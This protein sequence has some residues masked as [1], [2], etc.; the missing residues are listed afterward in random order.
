M[1]E[2][3][4][5]DYLQAMGITH[6]VPRMALPNAPQ[7]RWIA[8][9]SAHAPQPHQV[10][11]GEGHIVHPMA[12]ELLHDAAKPAVAKVPESR[13]E[14]LRE[15]AD[16]QQAADRGREPAPAVQPAP[17]P[18]AGTD[19]TPPRFELQFLRVSHY[20]VWVSDQPHEMER[21]QGFA[22]R[23]LQ[24]MT[25]NTGFMQP[26]FNFRWPFIESAHEDQS[27]PV[28]V[29]ALSAQWRFFADQGARYVV[30][31]G[32]TSKEW[33]SNIGVTPLF[34]GPSLAEVMQS[35]AEKRRLWYALRELG[36]I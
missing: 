18:A 6:W 11:A 20:G 30:S 32:D 13:D 4:R 15:E 1:L 36:D 33:L 3:R 35:A 10:S 14:V 8:E 25:D 16:G 5:Q 29:Q 22:W 34:A 19:L 27:H 12:A 23:V 31:F 17:M 2:Q 26:P 24:A 7:P 21:L 28:A 9:S